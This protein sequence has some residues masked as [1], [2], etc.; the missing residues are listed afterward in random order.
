MDDFQVKVIEKLPLADSVMKVWHWVAG[1]GLLE[2]VWEDN[3]GR[4]YTDVI[5]FP[6]MLQLMSD[7]LLKYESGRESFEKNIQGELLGASIQ[8]AYQ[9]LSRI[10]VAVSEAL[11]RETTRSL[12]EIFPKCSQSKPP[13]SL[14]EL[15]IVIYDGKVLKR[16]AKRLKPLRGVPGGLLGGRALVAMEWKTGMAVAM[17]CDVDG[18]ANDVKYVGELVPEVN[19]LLLGHRLHVGDRGFCDLEQP[20]HFTS[21][22]GD[23]FLV[24]HHPKVKFHQDESVSV[25]HGK[26]ADGLEYGERWGWLG[27]EKDRRRRYVRR[28]ELLRS[29]KES[30]VLITDLLDGKLYPANDLLSVYLERWE[31]ERLFQKVTE[32]FGLS[33]LIGGTPKATIF[34]FSYCMILYNLIQVVRGLMAQAH[35]R[36]PSDISCEK[37]FR[38]IRRELTTWTML[39]TTKSSMDYLDNRS[40]LEQLQQYLDQRLRNTWSN[41]WLKSPNQKVRRVTEK[42]LRRTH[43]S[44]QRLIHGPPPKKRRINYAS[45]RPLQQ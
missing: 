27:S 20:Q 4:C 42:K 12:R 23:H 1:G 40:E 28:I 26:N 34:Q 35:R 41:T 5:E 15:T 39:L 8:A 6:V 24:R 7:A 14:A 19:R 25:K 21:Q 43:N 11:L 30:V 45:R 18:D 33:H 9:K 29:G 10:P 17:R 22:P 13:A 2:A 32:V 38:D 44:V 3:R 36:E 31:I 16:V 37:M